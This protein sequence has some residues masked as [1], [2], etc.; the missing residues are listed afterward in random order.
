MVGFGP[1]SGGALALREPFLRPR[2]GRRPELAPLRRDL[3]G[4]GRLE[5]RLPGRMI[6]AAMTL[7]SPAISATATGTRTS[8]LAAATAHTPA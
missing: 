2:T 1:S 3:L 6:Q 7:D 5:F 4:L 8:L